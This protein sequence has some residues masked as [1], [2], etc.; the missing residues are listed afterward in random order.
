MTWI[1]SALALPQ[2]QT[3]VL[4]AGAA[5]FAAVKRFAARRQWRARRAFECLETGVRET[6]ES[7]VRAVKERS[8][9]GRLTEAD[10]REAVRLATETAK[11]YAAREGIDLLKVYAA[12]YLPVLI[13]RIVARRKGR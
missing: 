5:A 3:A 8:E 13:D 10:R 1:W 7:F 2:V 4:A 12:A 6:Y 11:R 9:D